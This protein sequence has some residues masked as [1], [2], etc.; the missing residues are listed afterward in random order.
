MKSWMK[1]KIRSG[2]VTETSLFFL[3]EKKQQ[4]RGKV[5]GSTSERQKDRN[6]NTAIRKL[7]RTLNCNLTRR[8]IMLTLTY[9]GVLPESLAEA[10][11]NVQLFFKKL[12][13]RGVTPAYV[14]VTSDKDSHTGESRRLHHHLIM[15]HTG[16]NLKYRSG[17]FKAAYVSGETLEDIWGHGM[18][19]VERI[20]EA[21][22]YTP[23][24]VYLAKQAAGGEN[25]KKWH[26]SRGLKKPEIISEEIVDR[27]GALRAPG[28]A[29]VMEIS[30][31]DEEIG[32]HYMRYVV[33][34]S[35]K[36]SAAKRQEIAMQYHMRS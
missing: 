28:G 14:W 18:I 19:K 21:D 25:V 29:E 22:D 16:I 8:W 17:E 35:R 30:E 32:T 23:L 31:Y 34:P 27:P 33:K 10:T 2:K 1:R 5:K 7:A 6:M 12:S 11:R 13:Y 20:E 3:G 24:A 15:T 26:C 36:K 9:E 4:R